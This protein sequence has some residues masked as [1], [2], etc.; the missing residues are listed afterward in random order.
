MEAFAKLIEHYPSETFKKGQTL[1]LKDDTPK[2]VYIIESGIVKAYSI[3]HDGA[4]RLVAIHTKGE[5]IPAGYG[6]GLAQTSQYFYESY[7]QCRIRFVPRE[8]FEN[9]MRT[10]PE[11]MYQW[12]MRSEK[13]LMATFLRVNAL[14][15]PRA[16]DKIAFM[17]LYMAT[18]LG[19]RL[20]PDK[21]RLKLNI[22]QQEIADALGITRETA[23]SELKK[24][25]LKHIISHSRKKYILYME[26][27]KRY[28]DERS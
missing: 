18:Q 28:L 21:T 9:Y 3:T 23:G 14:E 19:V 13:L 20:R 5:D 4:E 26:R 11:A 12:H 1:L 27:L 24:L 16:S 6:F 10:N 7:T 17:M 25:E 2:A 22:T 15:Q 8:V